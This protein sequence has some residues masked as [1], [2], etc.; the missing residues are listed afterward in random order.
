MFLVAHRSDTVNP[1]ALIWM[2]API[3]GVPGFDSFQVFGVWRLFVLIAADG[4][5]GLDDESVVAA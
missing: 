2:E 3:V 4:R 1:G 5:G